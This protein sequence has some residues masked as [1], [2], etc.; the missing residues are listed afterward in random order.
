MMIE[1]GNILDGRYEI[2]SKIGQGGMSYVYRAK[3][4]KLDRTVAIKVLKEECAGDEEFLKKFSNEARSAANLTHPNIVAAYDAV[5]EGE[6]HYI[7]MELVEGITLKNYIARKGKLSNKETI[8]ISLQAA[9][10]IAAAHKKGIIHRDIKPQ[11]LIISKDGKVKVAD[12]G[13][14]RLVSQDTQNSA[15]VGSV[16]YI[17]PEQARFG[18]ADER[19]DLYSLGICMYEMITGKL[20][21][22]GDNTVNVVMAHISEAMVPPKVYSPDIYPALNDIIVKAAKKEPKDRYQSAQELIADLKRCVNEPEGHFVKLFDTVEKKPEGGVS[23]EGASDSKASEGEDTASLKGQERLGS[24]EEPSP[25]DMEQGYG[26]TTIVLKRDDGL[27]KDGLDGDDKIRR[28]KR[29][30]LIGGG[31][32]MFI[33]IVGIIAFMSTRWGREE[34]PE[35]LPIEEIAEST[36]GSTEAEPIDITVEIRPEHIMPSLLGKT[37]EEAAA[38]LSAYG[39]SIDSSRSDFSDVYL[40][41]LIIGQVPEEG[42]ELVAGET[43]YVT[44]SLGTKLNNVLSNMSGKTEEEVRSELSEL[45]IKVNEQSRM[46]LSEDIEAG[47]VIG[48]EWDMSDNSSE[49]GTGSAVTL[50]ISSGAQDTEISMPRLLGLSEEQ[51][52]Y[53]LNQSGLTLLSLTYETSDEFAKGQ[54]CY[55]SV[56][57]GSPVLTGTSIGIIVSLG[58]SELG[59]GLSGDYYYGSIDTV[60]QVGLASGPNDSMNQIM[61]AIRLKQR[62]NDSY[63]YTTLE[64]AKPV[65]QG[66]WIPVSFRNIRGAY[67][68]TEGQVE[69]INAVSQQVLATF[70]VSFSAPE[71]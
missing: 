16:H 69:V 27:F 8:G 35:T 18:Q 58:S 15:V 67:G 12:F 45:G 43:V 39:V 21:F 41:G 29:Y 44:V 60:C 34:A 32:I 9:E 40:E 13:I 71:A 52:L 6:L 57:E 66:S 33:L 38:E 49:V 31:A 61:V 63:A 25:E 48:Y 23:E 14:A 36:M 1:A 19:S 59:S 5:D 30:G 2:E 42:Q 28:Y 4:T 10:G 37:V 22:M 3:D 26:D 56:N 70:D 20:P 54:V 46:E 55:Q 11:N 47:R 50:I 7:V 53:A 68:V 17:A 24:G 51:A 65:S 62:V 64:E